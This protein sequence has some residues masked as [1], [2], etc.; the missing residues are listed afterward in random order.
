MIFIFIY[1]TKLTHEQN[2]YI[3]CGVYN[4]DQ[5]Y[6]SMIKKLMFLILLQTGN[7][8]Y[9]QDS[10]CKV[11][12]PRL[13][14]S[15]SGEC[16]KGLAHGTGVAQGIDKYE[17]EFRKGLPEGR[18]VYRWADGT[19]YD[20]YWKAGFREGVGK[21]IYPDSTVTGYWKAD[22]YVGR[23]DVKEYQIIQSRFVARSTFNKISNQ[24]NQVKV[25]LTL[26]GSPNTSVQD[27]SMVYTSGEEFRLG[28]VYGIQ[29]VTYPITVRITYLTWNVLH[30]VQTNVTFEFKIN[31][32]GTWEVNIQN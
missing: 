26:G 9:A 1:T 16:K 20:G 32:P 7:L 28:T 23:E 30:T 8:I 10:D 4:S 25:K 19:F 3:C 14:G 11:L 22:K 31:V 2:W 21:M 29:N 15:Y 18:G 12:L 5:N 13:S 27:F 6:N 17:G 24:V